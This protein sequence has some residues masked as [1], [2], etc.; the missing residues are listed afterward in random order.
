MDLMSWY[1]KLLFGAGAAAAIVGVTAAMI[2]QEKI[3]TLRSVFWMM[4]VL[5]FAAGMGLIT[6]Y[7]H[8]HE[9]GDEGDSEETTT[10]ATF[11]TA[12]D[13]RCFELHRL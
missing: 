6:L 12:D 7:Y 10:A 8:L 3:W 5:I 11:R 9:G 1:W 2:G 4:L 13:T